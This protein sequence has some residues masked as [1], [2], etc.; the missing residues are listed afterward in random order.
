MSLVVIGHVFFRCRGLKG[1]ALINRP[2]SL[3]AIGWSRQIAKCIEFAFANGDKVLKV[4][5]YGSALDEPED[6]FDL[7]VKD[8]TRIFEHIRLVEPAPDLHEDATHACEDART[9]KPQIFPL[10]DKP[11]R[12]SQYPMEDQAPQ[13]VPA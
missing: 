5:G 8:V 11:A 13:R 4:G 10:A 6:L 1:I 2:T 3:K 12:I 7:Q 9:R